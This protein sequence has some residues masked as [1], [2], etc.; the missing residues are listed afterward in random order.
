MVSHLRIDQ[1]RPSGR[2]PRRSEQPTLDV[3]IVG[4]GWGA[5]MSAHELVSAG[6]RV[7][8]VERGDWVARGPRSWERDATLEL[9]PAAA[10]DTARRG[11][12]PVLTVQCVGGASVFAGGAALRFRERD[13]EPEDELV[14]DS[15]ARWPLRYAELEPWYARAEMLLG[16]SGRAGEDPCEPVRSTPFP[17]AA[18]ARSPIAEQMAAAA[19]RV[20]YRPFPLPL[21]LPF[22][23]SPG[24]PVCA[25]CTHCD[26]FACAVGAKRDAAS[27]VLGPLLERGLELQTGVAAIE[28][29][30]EDRT[31]V[32]V[33]CRDEATGAVELVRARHVVL[34]A[35]AL[36]SPVLLQRSGLDALNPAGDAVG[37]YLTRHCNAIVMGVFARPLA[38]HE[39]FHKQVAIHDLY[40]Q[41]G[42][43][44]QVGAP[45]EGLLHHHAP[46]G[47]R[48]SAAALRKRCAGWLA[49]A[50]DQPR[51]DNRVQL[52]P[53][54]TRPGRPPRAVVAHR[55]GPRD[56]ARRDQLVARAR[57]ILRAA[58]AQHVT[59]RPIETFS[60]A[61][62]TVRMGDDPR[63]APLDGDCRFRGV[64]NLHVI[65]GSCLPTSA[66]VNPSLTIAAVALRAGA[67]L[68]TQLT[69]AKA[70]IHELAA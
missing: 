19:A 21:A 54:A 57:A 18:P 42:G 15:G 7:R 56:L 17:Q 12:E 9:H 66:A 10:R 14:A 49:I 45:P 62:G 61:L 55:Y 38:A 41:A 20:G 33:L 40:E 3:L 43:L 37:R 68:A 31:V 58:G 1:A 63:S 36:A 32:G 22:T 47:L 26:T 46:A 23:A 28:L 13:F 65:D 50:E 24:R 6:L 5:A 64:D 69:S 51:A 59:V 67:R 27:A 2:A 25:R 30:H 8:I 60:H 39:T 70:G 11:D 29:V 16:V 34:S 4:S 52:D 44:Q 48:W 53:H 35:G